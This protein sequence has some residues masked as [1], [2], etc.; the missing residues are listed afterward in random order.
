MW[1]DAPV[2]DVSAETV[3]DVL[4]VADAYVVALRALNR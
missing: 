2:T 1:W 4:R 3:L